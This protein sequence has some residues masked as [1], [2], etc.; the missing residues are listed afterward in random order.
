MSSPALTLAEI[1]LPVVSAF[2]LAGL[3][4]LIKQSLQNRREARAA[5]RQVQEQLRSL[6]DRFAINRENITTMRRD[7]DGLQRTVPQLRENLAVLASTMEHHE[8][9]HERMRN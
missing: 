7:I 2:L 6:S 1:E 8:E 3:G 9:W 4:Y 5:A